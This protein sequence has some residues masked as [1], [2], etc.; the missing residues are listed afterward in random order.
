M[1][2]CCLQGAYT[3]KRDREKSWIHKSKIKRRVVKSHYVINNTCVFKP[4][5]VYMWIFA[6]WIYDFFDRLFYFCFWYKFINFLP[7][8]SLL[9][10][11]CLFSGTLTP[12][13]YFGGPFS[14]L[15][16][17]LQSSRTLPKSF[18]LQINKHAIHSSNPQQTTI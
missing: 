18:S 3:A 2:Y 11:F 1:L 14:R 10:T 6:V 15:L 4:A 13:H 17:F 9:G 16:P 12:F 8:E 7:L 5:T